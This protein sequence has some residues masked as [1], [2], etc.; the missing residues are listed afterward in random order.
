MTGKQEICVCGDVRSLH[1][2]DAKCISD[3]NCK[4]TAYHPRPGKKRRRTESYSQPATPLP[5]Q[6]PELDKE[7]E[8]LAEI[9]RKMKI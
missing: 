4:C 6:F 1:I 3:V 5:S 2:N 7:S 9:A 8:R